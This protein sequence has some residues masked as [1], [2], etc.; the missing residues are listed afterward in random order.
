M[1]TMSATLNTALKKLLFW[2]LH[3]AV[4]VIQW[5]FGQ[6][7]TSEHFLGNVSQQGRY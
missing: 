5:L 4:A 1:M 6:K 3:I 7:K 2:V